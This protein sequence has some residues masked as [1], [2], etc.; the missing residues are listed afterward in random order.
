MSYVTDHFDEEVVRLLKNG[1]VGFMPSDTIYGLSCRALD[2]K[3]AERIYK[4]K[5]RD[6]NKPFIV[7]IADLLQLPKLGINSFPEDLVKNYWPGALTIVFDSSKVPTWLQLGSASLAVRLPEGTTLRKLIGD[8][9]PIVSTSANLAGGQPAQSVA[10]AKKYFGDKLD[11]Y[12]DTGRLRG[13]PSTVAKF[14]FDGGIEII[15]QGAVKIS[16]RR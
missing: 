13:K 10:Q 2:K 5:K 15:R 4:L 9:G 16:T 12:V 8:I 6:K 1:A 14:N 3:A 7:L 11:F